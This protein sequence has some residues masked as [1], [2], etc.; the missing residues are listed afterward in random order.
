M[1]APTGK[2][3]LTGAFWGGTEGAPWGS[4]TVPPDTGKRTRVTPFGVPTRHESARAN[5]LV[6]V[7]KKAESWCREKEPANQ[8]FLGVEGAP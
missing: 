2:H 8:G 7:T 1:T 6:S 4:I 3:L 5:A